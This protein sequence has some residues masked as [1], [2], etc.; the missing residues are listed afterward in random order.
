[1]KF[2]LLLYV[3][4]QPWISAKFLSLGSRAEERVNSLLLMHKYLTS[5]Y[6]KRKQQEDSH[7]AQ[8]YIHPFQMFAVDDTGCAY[9]KISLRNLVIIFCT[10]HRT[11]KPKGTLFT[12]VQFS[13]P[14]KK[15]CQTLPKAVEVLILCHLRLESFIYIANVPPTFFRVIIR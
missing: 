10:L 5:L 4:T 9:G 14:D 8:N 1:M 2:L 12:P 3:G 11:M 13:F 6:L 7:L 15:E